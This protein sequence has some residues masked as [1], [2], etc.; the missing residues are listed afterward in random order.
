MVIDELLTTYFES[1]LKVHEAFGYHSDWV[2]IPL[3]DRREM[4]WMLVGGEGMGASCV[5]SPQP[6][7]VKSIEEGSVI[8]SGHIYTQRFLKKWVY[9]TATHALISVDTQTDGN[10]FLMVFD[11]AKECTDEEKRLAY[12]NHWGS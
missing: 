3:D 4:Y 7:T 2:E 9:R 10:K 12:K 8:Y 5:W 6:L 1:K 11:V